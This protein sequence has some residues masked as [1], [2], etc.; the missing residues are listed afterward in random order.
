MSQPPRIIDY[1]SGYADGL[2]DAHTR[3]DWEA[4]A[5][6]FTAGIITAGVAVLVSIVTKGGW[7]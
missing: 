6:G 7:L 4:F 1:A 2:T 5:L 3:F